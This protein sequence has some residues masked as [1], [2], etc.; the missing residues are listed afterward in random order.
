MKT[1]RKDPKNIRRARHVMR[2]LGAW[3]AARYLYKRGWSLEA[4]RFILLQK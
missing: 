3:V 4:A 2:T 1:P